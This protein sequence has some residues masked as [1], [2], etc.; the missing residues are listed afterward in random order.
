MQAAMI[1]WKWKIGSISLCIYPCATVFFSME[2]LEERT[3]P[4]KRRRRQASVAC[5]GN[6][7]QKLLTVLSVCVGERNVY[8]SVN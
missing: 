7:V 6:G 3:V 2:A 1:F 5:H 8:F 4:S